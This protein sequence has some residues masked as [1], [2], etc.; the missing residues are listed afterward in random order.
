MFSANAHIMHKTKLCERK[1]IFPQYIFAGMN[2]SETASAG[3][4]GAY[5][6]QARLRSKLPEMSGLLRSTVRKALSRE[7]PTSDNSDGTPFLH[8]ETRI[9]L[10][11]QTGNRC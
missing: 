4:N 11:I 8:N 3:H 9:E 2:K 5:V 1:R 6:F 10:T 7:L